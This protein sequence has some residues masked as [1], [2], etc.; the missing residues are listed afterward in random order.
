MSEA[1]VAARLRVHNRLEE[2]NARYGP[3]DEQLPD[4]LD[5]EL[6][7]SW[8][9]AASVEAASMP[10]PAEPASAP[11]AQ[12]RVQDA[13]EA[14]LRLDAYGETPLYACAVC[15]AESAKASVPLERWHCTACDSWGKV[16]PPSP[17]PRTADW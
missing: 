9:A 17:G 11:P 15:G 12:K 10:A 8:P 16:R 7:P 2:L 1:S 5:H 4:W 13:S 6:E 3:V 14:L